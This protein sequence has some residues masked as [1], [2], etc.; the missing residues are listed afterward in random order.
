MRERAGERN[1]ER[2]Q[3]RERARQKAREIEGDSNREQE[4]RKEREST[5]WGPL[6]RLIKRSD[7]SDTR[8]LVLSLERENEG[9]GPT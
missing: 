6:G 7:P 2:E 4:S 1:I 8:A 9:G 3:T 5:V